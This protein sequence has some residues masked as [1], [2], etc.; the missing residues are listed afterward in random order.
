MAR[1]GLPRVL[2]PGLLDITGF[3]GHPQ[4]RQR[5]SQFLGGHHLALGFLP[6]PPGFFLTPLA[7]QHQS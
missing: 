2:A 3:S 4:R 7:A 5:F 6:Q 1:A